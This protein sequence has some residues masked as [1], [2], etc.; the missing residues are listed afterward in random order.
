MCPDFVTTVTQSA[1]QDFNIVPSYQGMRSCTLQQVK[2]TYLHT[3]VTQCHVKAMP[4]TDVTGLPF[5]VGAVLAFFCRLGELAAVSVTC[6][7]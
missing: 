4:G 3:P 2:Q 7:M 6:H 1:N 5:P